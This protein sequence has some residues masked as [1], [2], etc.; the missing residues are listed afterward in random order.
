MWE[1]LLELRDRPPVQF[2]PPPAGD[3]HPSQSVK[4]A[5]R[6]FSLNTVVILF[7]QDS[8]TRSELPVN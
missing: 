5:N 6:L 3:V 1:S 4:Y 8:S 2:R 7:F